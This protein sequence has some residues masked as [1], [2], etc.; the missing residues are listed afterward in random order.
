MHWC[1]SEPS[2]DAKSQK[3]LYDRSVSGQTVLWS[4]LFPQKGFPTQLR[5]RLQLI[6]PHIQSILLTPPMSLPPHTLLV[7]A[8]HDPR[9]DPPGPLEPPL[10]SPTL[11]QSQGGPLPRAVVVPWDDQEPLASGNVQEEKWFQRAQDKAGSLRDNNNP[12]PHSMQD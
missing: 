7:R 12:Q 9:S 5:G 2:G 8:P 6:T 11:S 3:K 4:L 1:I 10:A